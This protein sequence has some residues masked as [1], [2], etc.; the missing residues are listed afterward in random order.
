VT[1]V[2]AVD[3][4]ALDVNGVE[5]PDGCRPTIDTMSVDEAFERSI[6]AALSPGAPH[7]PSNQL[8]REFK[9][10]IRDAMV[11]HVVKGWPRTLSPHQHAVMAYT[12]TDPS[13]QLRIIIDYEDEVGYQWRRTD[14]G[15]PRRT[16]EENDN[17]R[18]PGLGLLFPEST[19]RPR[20]EPQRQ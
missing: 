1:T 5:V 12:T 10:A 9:Q 19:T 13:Y 7:H 3:V 8:V 20:N 6:I 2:L 4:K 14:T 16:D 18:Q 11:S 15:Q 17:G